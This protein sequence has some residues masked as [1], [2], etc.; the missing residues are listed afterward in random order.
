MLGIMKMR[1]TLYLESKSNELD[2][3]RTV[4]TDRP[5]WSLIEMCINN[6]FSFGGNAFLYAAVAGDDDRIQLGTF[7][8]IESHPGEF[9]LIYT[10][11]KSVGEKSM[12]RVWWEPGD[13]PFRGTNNFNDTD[14]DDRTV[15]RDV[16]VAI[17]MF[18]DFFDHG[19]LTEISLN[20]MYSGW[21]RKAR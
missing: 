20:K 4:A 15:C 8:A 17:E 11:E 10:P 1:E 5:V 7:L 13:A 14:W 6:A 21:D 18:R 9:R 19:D 3:V 16:S 12:R 2:G